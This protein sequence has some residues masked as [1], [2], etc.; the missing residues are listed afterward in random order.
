MRRNI[1]VTK[2]ERIDRAGRLLPVDSIPRLGGWLTTDDQYAALAGVGTDAF[3]ADPTEIA[4]RAYR[5]LDVDGLID[6]HLPEA[7]GLYRDSDDYMRQRF[8]RQAR[9]FP[10]PE[11]ARD[12]VNSMAAP[13]TLARTFD[14]A[15]FEEDL[16]RDMTTMQ[17]RLGDIVWMPGHIDSGV[18]SFRHGAVTFGHRSYYEMIALYPD[19]AKRL[20]E[21]L[22]ETARLRNEVI[23][24]VYDSLN[25][26]ELIL[27]GDDI[28]SSSGPIV[29][30][31]ALDELYWP[32]VARAIQPLLDAGF[33]L[34]WHSDG[35][36][37]PIVDA[38]ID[39]GFAGFQ[40]FQEELGVHIADLV[41][42]HAADGR[43]LILFG[44]LSVS[45][46]LPDG[47]PD[48]VREAVAHSIRVTD[49]RGVFILS[50]NTINPDIPF[51]NIR[52]MYDRGT[53]A[54]DPDCRFEI[55]GGED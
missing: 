17:E 30:P 37:R 6:F 39:L 26:P 32:N 11:H 41:E 5:N 50:S 7:P 15:Q 43:R 2:R 53:V 47:T 54:D 38:I 46:T 44:S 36:V 25:C 18:C 3:W 28:C 22:G 16:T 20:Y 45:S 52:A 23:A 55:T 27:T 31:E 34:V 24:R 19:A 10:S 51:E 35:D 49:G 9:E 33:K 4:I 1:T 40:G 21:Y 29:S 13:E 12:Y 8:D 42:K 48:D 14:A